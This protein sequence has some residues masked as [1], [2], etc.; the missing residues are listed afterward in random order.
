MTYSKSSKDSQENEDPMHAVLVGSDSAFS[1]GSTEVSNAANVC[2][3]GGN[4]L[5]S[6][7]S[8]KDFYELALV[9]VVVSIWVKADA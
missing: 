2:T 7:F 5:R 4:L 3:N 1:F 9:T 8:S 6:I